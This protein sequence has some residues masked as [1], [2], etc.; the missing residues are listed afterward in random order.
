MRGYIKFDRF[1]DLE[2]SL[3][4]L[5][6]QIQGKPMTPT[7]WKWA[8]IAAH[9]ALQGSICIAL[10]GSAGFDT[11]KPSHLKKWLEAYEKNM[12]LPDP[13]LDYFME[14]FDRLFDSEPGIDR[15]L[16]KWLNESRNHLIHFNTDHYSIERKSII[17]AIDASVYATIEASTRS[18]GIFFYEEQQPER[19]HTLCESIRASLKMLVD[20]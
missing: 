1:I 11:W 3:E 15:N 4:Q 13:H 7:S 17:C 5:L 2:A 20:Y 14:L 12:D 8:L 16:I 10:R 19:F 6:S 9:S 18:K